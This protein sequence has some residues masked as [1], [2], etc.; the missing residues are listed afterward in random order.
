MLLSVGRQGLR[1]FALGPRLAT[2]TH[3]RM[4]EVLPGDGG[5]IGGAGYVPAGTVAAPA[6]ARYVAG[7]L[8][9]LA[10]PTAGWNPL[11]QNGGGQQAQTKG[12]AQQKG[13]DFLFPILCSLLS[14][15]S[16]TQS[17][18]RYV[19]FKNTR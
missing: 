5:G 3:S 4:A 1:E 11:R 8:R 18:K 17:K 7:V 12:E 16:Y 19:L 6:A 14:I 10:L 2:N 15:V 13:Y 9:D